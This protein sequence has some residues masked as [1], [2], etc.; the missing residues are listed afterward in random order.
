MPPVSASD[1]LYYFF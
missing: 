1:V